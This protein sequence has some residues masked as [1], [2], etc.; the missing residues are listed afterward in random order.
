MT[1][2]SKLKLPLNLQF[3]AEGGG[4][5]D[6]DDNN[7]GGDDENKQDDKQQDD[8]QQ[9]DKQQGGEKT[10][11]QEDVSNIAS[12]ESKA[13]VEKLLK[14][15][16]FD[17]FENAK[18]GVDKFKEH[19]E[20]QKTEQQKA[21]DALEKAQKTASEKDSAIQKLQYENAA[22]KQG[23]NTDAIDDVVALAEKRVTDDKDI[24]EAMK[25]VIKQYPQ[26]AQAAESDDKEEEKKPSFLSGEHGSDKNKKIDAFEALAQKYK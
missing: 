9:D 11:T 3:F 8:K 2:D 10:F 20:S 14:D 17:D 5:T 6:Q 22:L 19:Q 1:E 13:A 7:P 23:V 12:K 24:N 4:G 21:T 16:G 25:E 26:F 18:D 15:L